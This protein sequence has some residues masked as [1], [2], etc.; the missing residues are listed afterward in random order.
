MVLL[1]T[2]VLSNIVRKNPSLRLL[3][4]LE[5]RT[6]EPL[7]TTAVNTAEI[8][9]GAAR[10]PHRERI[11]RVYREKVFPQLTILPFDEECAP[12]F[13]E[14]KASLEKRG[15]PR[16][17]PDLRIAAVALRHR[18]TVITGNARHFAGLPHLR[19]EDWISEWAP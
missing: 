16:S 2:D 8:Y 3:S 7:F 11:L 4:E 6:G 13:G 10:S 15:E 17:E 1:D 19:V 18:L 5:R 14:L 12:I 9:F